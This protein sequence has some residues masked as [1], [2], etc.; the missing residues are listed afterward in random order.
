MEQLIGNNENFVHQAYIKNFVDLNLDW[1]HMNSE[2]L[3]ELLEFD[4]RNPA[5]QI[6]VSFQ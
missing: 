1:V 4:S 3:N 5:A 2:A 6:I